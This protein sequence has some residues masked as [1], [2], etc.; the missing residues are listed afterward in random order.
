MSR[1]RY[2][3]QLREPL[4]DG[5]DYDV[6]QRHTP[7]LI[8]RRAPRKVS[9]RKALSCVYGPGDS[10][11]TSALQKRTRRHRETSIKRTYVEPLSRIR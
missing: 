7:I 4:H 1:T 11:G 2:R 3:E 6:Q 5:K 10:A 8:S 9:P